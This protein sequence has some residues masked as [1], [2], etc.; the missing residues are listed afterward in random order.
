MLKGED[1]TSTHHFLRMSK[2]EAP[3]VPEA[4]AQHPAM[5]ERERNRKCLLR[6]LQ[7]QH[8]F[9][10]SL[11]PSVPRDAIKIWRSCAALAPQLSRRPRPR[12]RLRRS[13]EREGVRGLPLTGSDATCEA[14]FMGRSR[15]RSSIKLLASDLLAHG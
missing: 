11:S 2:K 9:P 14:F 4:S 6:L 15:C 13:A 3:M 7:R 5:S 12:R 8:N 1:G 10:L